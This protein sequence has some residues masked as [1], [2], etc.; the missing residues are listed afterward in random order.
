MA[1]YQL[2]DAPA[3]FAV[4]QNVKLLI[5]VQNLFDT[6]PPYSN[7]GDP[8]LGYDPNYADPRGRRWTV[9]LRASWT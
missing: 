3:A 2:W 7:V 9:G 4:A 6:N 5:G 8:P 1:S